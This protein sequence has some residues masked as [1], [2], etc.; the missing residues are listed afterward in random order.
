MTW[1]DVALGYPHRH[2][3]GEVHWHLEQVQAPDLDQ[4]ALTL[5]FIRDQHLRVTNGTAEDEKIDRLR[6]VSYRMAERATWRAHI[7]Q[8]WTLVIDRFPC[9]DIEI[10]KAPLLS[11][12]EIT[13]VDT[14]G[15]EQTLTASPAQFD[16]T[17]P[18]GPKAGRGSVRPLVNQVWPTTRYQRDAV[19]ITF[20]AGYALAG[21]PALAT[22]PEDIDEGRLLVI[23]ELYKQRSESVHALSQSPAL[24]RA[25][26]LWVGYRSY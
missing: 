1:W 14:N 5:A 2:M 4:D 11:V 22:V 25:K 23:G 19:R 12:D 9:W 24:L 16:V 26:D 13:Y 3:G 15:D 21:S 10:P 17:A 6:K 18:S 20:T 7:P 8:Q